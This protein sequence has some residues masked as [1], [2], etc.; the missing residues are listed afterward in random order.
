MPSSKASLE[1]SRELRQLRELYSPT[2]HFFCHE[3][4]QLPTH[5]SSA[6]PPEM[7][8]ALRIMR[9]PADVPGLTRES[10]LKDAGHASDVV[11]IH[12]KLQSELMSLACKTNATMYRQ[13]AAISLNDLGLMNICEL[14]RSSTGDRTPESLYLILPSAD[15]T[16]SVVDAFG[17]PRPSPYGWSYSTRW[18][19]R[20]ND[21]IDILPESASTASCK[22]VVPEPPG[23][24]A[25]SSPL[26]V[27]ID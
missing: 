19:T 5:K 16:L 27:G 9:G 1:D 14:P 20:F 10:T 18:H 24:L 22:Q 3:T 8:G 4:R 23:P 26:D 11:T 12:G 15:V 25:L 13:A 21:M 2:F 7:Y 6:A 17:Y